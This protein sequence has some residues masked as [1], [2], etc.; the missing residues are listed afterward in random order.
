[1]TR[2]VSVVVV[3]WVLISWQEAQAWG[4][5]RPEVEVLLDVKAALD[6][7]SEV[8]VSWQSGGQP[9]NAGAFEGV[10]CDAGENSRS[11]QSPVSLYFVRKLAIQ[12]LH[13]IL[14][15]LAKGILSSS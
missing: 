4:P 14:K 11:R 15:L 9:C 5:S 6:P 3:V 10:L 13:N 7:H 2:I 1:M 8:L 12:F